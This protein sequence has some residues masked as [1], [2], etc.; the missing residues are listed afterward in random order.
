MPFFGGGLLKLL[1]TQPC[2]SD[3]THQCGGF[4]SFPGLVLI[5]QYLANQRGKYSPNAHPIFPAAEKQGG[6]GVQSSSTVGRLLGS[7]RV[8]FIKVHPQPLPGEGEAARPWLPDQ[9]QWRQ[10]GNEHMEC[11]QHTPEDASS[12]SSA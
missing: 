10:A 12:Q 2:L 1:Y 4:L 7:T 9:S 8:M 5:V 6:L 11:L 3:C